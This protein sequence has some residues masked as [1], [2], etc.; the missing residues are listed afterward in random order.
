MHHNSLR[1]VGM[2]N[3]WTEDLSFE[4]QICPMVLDQPSRLGMPSD[5]IT[6]YRR[7]KGTRVLT[8]DGRTL[9]AIVVITACIVMIPAGIDTMRQYYLIIV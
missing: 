2:D 1:V 6:D 8:D 5:G 9:D 7:G 4:R 3:S